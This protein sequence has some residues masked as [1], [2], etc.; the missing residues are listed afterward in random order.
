MLDMLVH[1][2]KEVEVKYDKAPSAVQF[3]IGDHDS[4]VADDGADAT[5]AIHKDKESEEKDAKDKSKTDPS[6]TDNLEVT[7]HLLD[8]G[9]E[10]EENYAKD[11]SKTNPSSTDNLECTENFL[12]KSKEIE[13][14]YAKDKSKTDPSSTDNPEVTE[15]GD[16]QDTTTQAEWDAKLAEA[17]L[18][19]QRL[20]ALW[21][22]KLKKTLRQKCRR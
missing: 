4:E 2:S 20:K 13:E 10:I 14:E 6:S 15:E 18:E 11:K 8:K 12:D 19:N 5:M 9:K 22:D 1:K 21:R 16:V 3:Y 17:T 7:E